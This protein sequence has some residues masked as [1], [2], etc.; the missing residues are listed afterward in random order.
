[1]QAG[2]HGDAV[3]AGVERGRQAGAQVSFGAFMVSFS[4]QF[5]KIRPSPFFAAM[6]APT[7]RRVASAR[8]SRS[9]WTTDLSM[10][11]MLNL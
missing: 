11:L 2:R 6:V 4:M 7:C 5:T 10:L 8:R 9:N 1:V 3:D